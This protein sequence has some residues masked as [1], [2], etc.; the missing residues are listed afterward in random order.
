MSKESTACK[1]EDLASRL[2][3]LIEGEYEILRCLDGRRSFPNVHDKAR[4]LATVLVRLAQKTD[5]DLA[6]V[7]REVQARGGAK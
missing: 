1:I 5:I 7:A 6:A 3:P 2:V 4:S